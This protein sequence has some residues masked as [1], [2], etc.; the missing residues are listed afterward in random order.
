VRFR[1][2]DVLLL[3]DATWNRPDLW[4]GVERARREGARVIALVYDL[5]PLEAGHP[6][7]EPL[8]RAFRAWLE[9]MVAVADGAIAISATTKAA[10]AEF[11]RPRRDAFSIEAFRLGAELDGGGTALGARASGPHPGYAGL[12]PASGSGAPL[13][14]MVGTLEPRKNHDLV[15]DAFETLW[16]EDSPARLEIVGRAPW[17]PLLA[18]IRGHRELGARL[19]HRDDA[20][21]RALADLYERATATICASSG[22]GFGLPAVEALARGCP[23]L[24]SDIPAFREV[25][26][27]WCQYFALDRASLAAALRE[28]TAGSL[29]RPRGFTWPTWEES[30][31]ELGAALA[32]AAA[33]APAPPNSAERAAR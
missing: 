27:A 26:G 18:R 32:R 9:W 13:F 28:A 30:A 23:V 19:I 1:P 4:P 15:L 14:L 29:P 5:L 3:A 2:G 21:D 31:R 24:A 20:D 25:S 22:E 8:A 7:Y 17:P 33:P 10:L 16:A 11:A 12:R 6:Y